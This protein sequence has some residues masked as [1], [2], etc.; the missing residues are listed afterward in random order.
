MRLPDARSAAHAEG[1]FHPRLSPQPR[2]PPEWLR[3]DVLVGEAWS[4]RDL[5]TCPDQQHNIAEF[6]CVPRFLELTHCDAFVVCFKIGFVQNNCNAYVPAS[7]ENAGCL[8]V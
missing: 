1:L 7:T 6:A 3:F 8:E 4:K 2:L 5:T